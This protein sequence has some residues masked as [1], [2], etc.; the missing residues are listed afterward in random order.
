[1]ITYKVCIQKYLQNYCQ[2]ILGDI[3]KLLTL[4]NIYNSRGSVE[5][6]NSAAVAAA[7]QLDSH[8]HEQ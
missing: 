6:E 7:K 8:F 3:L 4:Y 2:L 5:L 1:M